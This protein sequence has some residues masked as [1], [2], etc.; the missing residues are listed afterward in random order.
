MTDL[1]AWERDPE[2]KALR[3]EFIASLPDRMASLRLFPGIGEVAPETR[4]VI[5]RLAGVAGSY[6]FPAL[7]RLAG[8]LDDVLDLPAAGRDRF[9]AGGT[10]IWV[11]AQALRRG[12]DA[13]YVTRADPV[14]II[15]E[16]AVAEAIFV[17]E[18]LA[19]GPSPGSS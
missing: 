7:S 2:L 11:L 12:V 13:A 19:S 10:L 18:S 3:D 8:A 17:A 16:D 14:S 1:P 15:E 4:Q 6:G 9:K 5:H